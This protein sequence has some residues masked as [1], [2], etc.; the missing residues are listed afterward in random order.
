MAAGGSCFLCAAHAV[1]HLG[2]LALL[3]AELKIVKT[4]VDPSVR[5]KLL[6][7]SFLDKLPFVE[8]ENPVDVSDRRQPVR[9]DEARSARSQGPERRADANLRLRVHARGGLVQNEDARIVGEGPGETQ[10]L[11]LP[12]GK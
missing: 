4:G 7:R 2:F 10:Q 9:D 11:A 1:R 6:M 12:R 8:H 5:Q 3:L